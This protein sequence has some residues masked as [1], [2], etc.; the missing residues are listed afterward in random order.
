MTSHVLALWV[1]LWPYFSNRGRRISTFDRSILPEITHS[2]NSSRKNRVCAGNVYP[3][4][5]SCI[6]R[7][8]RQSMID[9]LWFFSFAMRATPFVCLL[10][11]YMPV[12]WAFTASITTQITPHHWKMLFWIV[13]HTI[14]IACGFLFLRTRLHYRFLVVCIFAFVDVNFAFFRRWSCCRTSLK[15]WISPYNL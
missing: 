15:I 14:P 9:R 10:D 7:L 2:T 1:N 11:P 8:L 12:Y 3:V 4:Q 6:S 13:F 5:C